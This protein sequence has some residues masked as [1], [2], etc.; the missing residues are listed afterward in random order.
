MREDKTDI[1]LL[2]GDKDSS[3]VVVSSGH[4]FTGTGEYIAIFQ[5][6]FMT[7][8]EVTS[9]SN[10]TILLAGV[11]ASALTGE[12]T[13]VRGS[14]DMAVDGSS[15]PQLFRFC[16][17]GTTPI[18]VQ[19]VHITLWNELAQGDEG[20]FGDQTALTNGLRVYKKN[21]ILQSLGVYKN[22]SDF[23]DYGGEV[24]YH[25]KAPAGTY[26]ISIKI[27]INDNFGVVTRFDPKIGDEMIA[28]AR[29]DY[30]GLP[31]FKISLLG[32]HTLGE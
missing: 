2:A 10:D 24:L 18:D 19:T 13:V 25:D 20:T 26:G 17:R 8:Q 1:T 15:T 11:L 32:H 29:D 5:G 6:D 3:Y 21:A 14:V 12:A 16:P 9:V 23:R 28:V 31:K 27:E 7:Q 22:N 4:G 30:S